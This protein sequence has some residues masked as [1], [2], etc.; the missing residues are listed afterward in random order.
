VNR[1]PRQLLGRNPVREMLPI[2]LGPL[3]HLQDASSLPSNRH[4][5]ARLTITP[6]ACALI[7]GSVSHQRR[8]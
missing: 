2:Q 8:Q 1:P 7:Q 4:D 3:I 5:Q 6:I